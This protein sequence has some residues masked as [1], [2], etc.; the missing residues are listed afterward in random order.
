MKSDKTT[1][2]Y[3]IYFSLVN[4]RT[5]FP[6]TAHSIQSIPQTIQVPPHFAVPTF[7]RF[8]TYLHCGIR[9]PTTRTIA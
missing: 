8:L 2:L 4:S 7:K 1:I 9:I 5:F 3:S 6:T